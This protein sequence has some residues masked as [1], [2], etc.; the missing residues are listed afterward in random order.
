MNRSHPITAILMISTVSSAH[1]GN[2]K[3]SGMI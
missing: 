1:S 2:G 3:G